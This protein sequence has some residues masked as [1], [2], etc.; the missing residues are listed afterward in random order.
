VA[1]RQLDLLL[2]PFGRFL[3]EA[4]LVAADDVAADGHPP[5]AVAP[6]DQ[7]LAVHHFNR[8]DLGQRDG[9]AVGGIDGQLTDGPGRA[10]RALVDPG[11]DVEPP[12]AFVQRADRLAA[13]SHVDQLGNVLDADV[14][15]CAHGPVRLD[16]QLG[17]RAFLFDADVGR[18]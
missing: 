8:G 14:V 2:E 17:L 6:G 13:D 15:T 16:H 7:R 9:D 10:A 12:V 11:D 5:L 4:A 3:D 1:G 18:A